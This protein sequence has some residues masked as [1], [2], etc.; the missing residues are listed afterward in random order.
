MQMQMRCVQTQM[1][2]GKD[3]GKEI[4]KKTHCV[5]IDVVLASRQ[6]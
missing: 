1:V 5:V 3:G 6:M 4:R 2:V